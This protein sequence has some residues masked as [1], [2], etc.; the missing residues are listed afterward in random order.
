[1][2][3]WSIAFLPPWRCDPTHRTR[4]PGLDSLDRDLVAMKSLRVVLSNDGAPW[5]SFLFVSRLLG[6][7]MWVV[8]SVSIL[9][10]AWFDTSALVSASVSSPMSNFNA[11]PMSVLFRSH[12]QLTAFIESFFWFCVSRITPGYQA[13]LQPTLCR[14][15]STFSFW[16]F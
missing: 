12:F 9:L 1:M 2:Y 13:R 3:R 8:Y 5:V 7:I 10:A 15:Y 11:L 14:V 16:P 6:Q 4:T